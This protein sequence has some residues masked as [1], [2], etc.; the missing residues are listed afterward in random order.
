[1]KMILLADTSQTR[2]RALS[3]ALSNAGFGV[4]A[5]EGL[6]EAY[7]ALMRARIGHGNLDAVVLGWPEYS[8]GVAED[9]FG[10]LHGERFEHLPVLVMADSSNANAVNW[11]M[12]RPRTALTFWSEYLEAPSAIGHLLRPDQNIEPA[13]SAHDLLP[14]GVV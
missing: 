5:V 1:M 4:T 3:A 9:V 6:A 14:A 10:L 11:R 2:R 7:E 8:E 13:R 12:S